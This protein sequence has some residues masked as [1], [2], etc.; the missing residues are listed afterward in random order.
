M[1]KWIIPFLGL[2][3]FEAIADIYAKQYGIKPRWT[4]FIVAL[5]FYIICNSCW[6]VA[7]KNGMELS[8]GAVL[9]SVISAVLACFIGVGL[10][11]ES[12]TWFE[13]IGILLGLLAIGLLNLKG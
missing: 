5:L 4:A 8:K 9:F 1:N 6:L 3:V 12:L 7:L 2:L 10:Y 13:W 11:K